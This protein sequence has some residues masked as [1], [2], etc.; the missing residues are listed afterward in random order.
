MSWQ[1]KLGCNCQECPLKDIRKESVA[2]E[3][4]EDP[5]YNVVTEPP[6]VAEVSI[7]RPL[8]TGGAIALRTALKGVGQKN[9]NIIPTLLC[10]VPRQTRE[11][12]VKLAMEC[13]R[14]RIL[15]ELDATIPT[16][17]LGKRAT[18]SLLK[19]NTNIDWRGHPKESPYFDGLCYPSYH[20]R[21][22]YGNPA[23]LKIFRNDM[24]RLQSRDWE[25]WKWPEF[26]IHENEAMAMELHRLLESDWVGFDYETADR[27]GYTSPVTCIGLCDREGGVSVPWPPSNPE[28]EDLT[29]QVLASETVGKVIHNLS[30]DLLVAKHNDHEVR[31]P[32]FG[33][34]EAHATIDPEVSHKLGDVASYFFPAPRWK[35]PLR[36]TDEEERTYNARDA[37]MTVLLRHEM[38]RI[39]E[40]RPRLQKIYDDTMKLGMIGNK[41]AWEG[42]RV[43]EERVERLTALGQER[44]TALRK[45]FQELAGYE[46]N[47]NSNQQLCKLFYDELEI[48]P[49]SFSPKTG[50]P[51]L[52]EMAL[53][54]I[55]GDD[56]NPKAMQLARIL[57]QYR[58]EAK[59][60]S[61]YLMPLKEKIDAGQS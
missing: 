32:I 10:R 12:E 5:K 35:V 48:P 38:A 34:I 2:S 17:L 37:Y 22:L 25:R 15:K 30:F 55:M 19:E 47:I 54:S 9:L 40:K 49:K 18:Q 27:S 52:D 29:R 43:S 53:E 41:M 6:T 11:K 4:A 16:I 56:T 21:F 14:P 46:L 3:F 57:Y 26:Q 58:K 24:R 7:G 8:S 20:P 51:S 33:T 39:L 1:E 13:C 28:I 31:G 44:T 36:S 23:Y 60:L 45:K 42:V 61:S 50:N 59:I